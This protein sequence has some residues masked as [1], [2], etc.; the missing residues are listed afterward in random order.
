M[1]STFGDGLFIYLV[2]IFLLQECEKYLDV[3]NLT[4]MRQQAEVE[5]NTLIPLIRHHGLKQ[6]LISSITTFKKYLIS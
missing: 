2:Y 1:N 4:V 3:F 6:S 5:V